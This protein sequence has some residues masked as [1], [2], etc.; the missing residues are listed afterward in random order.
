MKLR[1]TKQA[2]TKSQRE[3]N[4]LFNQTVKDMQFELLAKY[5]I[6]DKVNLHQQYYNLGGNCKPG[7][8]REERSNDL[9]HGAGVGYESGKTFKVKS[10][11]YHNSYCILWPGENGSGVYQYAVENAL[12]ELD[13]VV[14]DINNEL[15]S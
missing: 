9:V 4:L 14:L 15:N 7:F 8:N 12:S 11:S 1:K 6:D 13:L 3:Y 2:T 5:Q 10:V